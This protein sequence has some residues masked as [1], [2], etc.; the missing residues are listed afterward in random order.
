[1]FIH[2]RALFTVFANIFLNASLVSLIS[3]S[4]AEI[5]VVFI[6]VYGQYYK[7]P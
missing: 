6:F 5:K 4:L 3:F 2:A 7:P 1:M